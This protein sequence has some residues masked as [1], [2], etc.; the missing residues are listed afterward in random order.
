MEMM[1]RQY[2]QNER[3]RMARTGVAMPDGS[4]PI[5]NRADLQNAIQSVGRAAN[6]NAAKQHI[7]SR[8]KELKLE[9]LLPEE[10]INPKKMQKAWDGVFLPREWK[11]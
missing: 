10:W 5:R 7:M 9:N 11:A 6:Y 4:Y 3:E 8:A 2:S 1:K